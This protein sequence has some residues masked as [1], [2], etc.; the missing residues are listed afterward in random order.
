VSNATAVYLDR[1]PVDNP[2]STE[3]C[4]EV[5]FTYS[6]W[7]E[8]E[9]ESM[10]QDL[11]IPI[12]TAA[13]PTSPPIQGT[14]VSPPPATGSI[15][16][17]H[18]CTDITKIPDYWLEQAKQLT[19]HYAHTSHG[20][21]LV[22]GV[23][24]LERQ[25]A[26]YSV[27]VRY[28]GDDAGLLAE[29]G[30]LRICD[31]NPPGGDYIEPDD[32]WA[33]RAGLDRTRGVAGTGLFHFSMWSWCGQQS[34]NDT[35]TVQEYLD[36]LDQ[37]EQEFPAMRFI[38]MTGHTDGDN[39]ILDRNNDMV[40]QYARERGK[41]LFDFASIERYDPA[42]NYYPYADDSCIWCDD[43]CHS[44]PEDCQNLNQIDDCAHTHPLMCKLKGQAFWW[45]MARLA[46][47]DGNS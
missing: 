44:H 31:G 27:A 40:R 37:L 43:W 9:S 42:G 7:A 41:V 24:W 4:P 33:S 29:S 5:T 20:S 15:L 30:A 16:I 19:F 36:A 38:Y 17:D 13:L 14:P 39:E 35:G 34:D 2:G 10:G 26:T 47:W 25:D 23:E 46:G 21:Q 11:T 3:V 45:M 32:Y 18:T 28:C 6:L 8:N 1:E 12:G 22:T